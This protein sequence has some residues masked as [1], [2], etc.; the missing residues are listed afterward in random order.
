MYRSIILFLLIT[1][2]C[3]L[4]QA[5]EINIQRVWPENNSKCK[6]QDNR[7]LQI[8]FTTPIE[9]LGECT[10][11]I[12]GVWEKSKDGH[13]VIFRSDEV[14]QNKWCYFI[15][16]IITQDGEM[17]ATIFRVQ[18]ATKPSFIDK[19][20]REIQSFLLPRLIKYELSEVQKLY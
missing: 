4:S 13:Y 7:I 11:S 18:L 9:T 15:L 17:V 5:E 8:F 1:L 6:R 16:R 12:K 19:I 3:S 2:A 14:H 20:W 10:A